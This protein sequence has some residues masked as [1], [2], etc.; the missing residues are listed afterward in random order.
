MS[1]CDCGCVGHMPGCPQFQAL[2]GTL[3]GMLGGTDACAA[4]PEMNGAVL[5]IACSF[6]VDL[7][8]VHDITGHL[9]AELGLIPYRVFLV[10]EQRVD[11]EEF[12]EIRRIELMPVELRGLNEV[13]LVLAADGRA[14]EGKVLL[15]GISPNQVTADDLLGHV[16]GRPWDGDGER[17][18]IETRLHE[19]CAGKT[20]PEAMRWTPDGIPELRVARA[21]AGWMLRL[22]DQRVARGRHG[23]DRTTAIGEQ[24]EA[25]SR[26]DG[27]RR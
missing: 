14:P 15:V 25:S 13:R 4:D 9:E 1:G 5:S 27:L 24:P 22:T 21:P 16:E 26:Y 6:G 8:D 2:Q 20:K 11:G 7:A 18:F 12:T 23:E 10:W 3:I 17:F 19:R